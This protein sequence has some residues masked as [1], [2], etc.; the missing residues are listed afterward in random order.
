MKCPNCG[1]ET[2]QDRKNCMYCDC[3]LPTSEKSPNIQNITQNITYNVSNYDSHIVNQSQ[4]STIQV[5]SKGIPKNKWISFCLCL[6]TICGHKFYE[7]KTKMGVIYL[8]T[9]GLFGFGWIIDL[10]SLLLKPNP[11]YI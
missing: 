4:P 9:V 11:Y 5:E 2:P 8:F 6:F 10:I 1:A 3:E 7:G